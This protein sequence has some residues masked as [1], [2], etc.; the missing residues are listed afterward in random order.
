MVAAK[1]PNAAK[2]AQLDRLVPYAIRTKMTESTRTTAKSKSLFL[3]NQWRIGTPI[4]SPPT[5]WSQNAEGLS[6]TLPAAR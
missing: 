6:M 2:T 1:K 3:S 4:N 5:K